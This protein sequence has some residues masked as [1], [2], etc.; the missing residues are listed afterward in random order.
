VRSRT[1][2]ALATSALHGHR[3][4]LTLDDETMKK[5]ETWP[6]RVETAPISLDINVLVAAK[7]AEAIDRG[8]FQVVVGPNLGGWAAGRNFGRFAHLFP[9]A[10]GRNMLTLAAEAE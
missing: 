3:R 10:L 9:A 1:L 2:L 6:A 4:V 5:L 7:S 8:E